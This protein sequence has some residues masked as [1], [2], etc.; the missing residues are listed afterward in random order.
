MKKLF[1][2]LFILIYSASF[3]QEY[4]LVSIKDIQYVS[5]DSLQAG[6]DLSRYDGDTVRVQ[7]VVMN[8]A[9]KNADPEDER[10][11][12]AG[13]NAVFLNESDLGPFGGILVRDVTSSDAF[14]ILDTGIVIEITGVVGTYSDNTQLNV[15]EFDAT[16]ILGQEERPKA[17]QL[18]MDSIRVEGSSELYWGSERWEQVYIELHNLTV[19]GDAIGNGSYT[20]VDEN[21]TQ[22]VIYTTSD[23]FRNDLPQPLPGTKIERLRGFIQNDNRAPGGI[24]VNPVYPDDVVYGDVIPPS[25]TDVQR[26]KGAVKF[27]E[28]VEVSAQVVDP[29]GEV[30]KV[31]LFYSVNEAEFQTVEMTAADGDS[32]YY[33]T[34]PGLADSSLVS[35]FIEATDDVAA[36]SLNP[37]DTS[38]SRYFYHVLDRDLQVQDIQYSPFGSG[39]S[40]YNNYLVT[41]TGV[42]TADTSDIEGDGNV[43]GPKVY[44]QNGTGPWSGIQIFGTEAIK[45]SKGNEVTVTGIV[46]E[47]FG[48]TRIEELDDASQITVVNESVELPDPVVLSTDVIGTTGDGQLPA[49]MY[50]SV[51]IK[52]EDV[53]V[54]DE[55]ADGEPGYEG[56]NFGEIT[57]SDNS[58]VQTRVEM[59]DGTHSYH[60]LYDASV[61]GTGIRVETGNTFE[62][63]VG[64]L[65]YSFGNYKLVPRT[66][67]DFIGLGTDIKDMNA[68]PNEY[69]LTQNYPNPFNP[70]TTIE[71]SIVKESDVTLRVFN[72]LGQEVKT[73]VNETKGVG[74]YKVTFNASNLSTGVYFYRLEADDFVSVKKMI[75]VK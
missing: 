54:I 31:N 55:N 68:I 37:T 32:I 73:L 46:N 13:A 14:A 27:N 48:L 49:E 6:H 24:V 15:V 44:I 18:P 28:D 2:L 74:N 8:A 62:G 50:E 29:D 67:D 19:S 11:L 63:L 70:T 3:A 30:S 61:E 35:Y 21:G 33:G 47:S 59:Q 7:G 56:S 9:F 39:Y 12:H 58:S 1:L 53:E 10:L 17:I 22:L 36:N 69:D 71:Y 25:V 64:I 41:V 52:Y 66:D 20:V 5:N 38:S 42:V 65:Y 4:P 60:N 72:L 45:L 34:I 16:G 51:L 75:L 40:G 43:S 23:I 57:V 26:D